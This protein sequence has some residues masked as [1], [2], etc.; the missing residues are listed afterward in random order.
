MSESCICLGAKELFI[1]N[2]IIYDYFTISL[3][4][5]G[6]LYIAEWVKNQHRGHGLGALLSTHPGSAHLVCNSDFRA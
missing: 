2:D 3:A 1:V 6:A 4:D 5:R